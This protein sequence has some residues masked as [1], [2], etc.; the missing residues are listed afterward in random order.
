MPLS[1]SIDSYLDL[2]PTLDEAL[3]QPIGMQVTYPTPGKAQHQVQRMY[4]LR[5]LDRARSRQV[6][7]EVDEQ[8]NTSPYD[9]L[10]FVRGDR[11]VFIR[12][13]NPPVAEPIRE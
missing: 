5:L 1:E 8:Y 4:K 2:R 10:D 6:Y 13:M 3:A 12:K 7:T 11:T 9:I